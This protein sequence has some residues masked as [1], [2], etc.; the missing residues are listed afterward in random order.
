ML[1]PIPVTNEVELYL[2]QTYTDR[3]LRLNEFPELAQYLGQGYSLRKLVF[4][5][6]AERSRYVSLSVCQVSGRNRSTCEKQ[7]VF[8]SRTQNYSFEVAKD[9]DESL[10]RL[11]IEAEGPVYI[12][13]IKLVLGRE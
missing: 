1:D 7:R 5:A 6:Q 9:Y 4:T 12:H 11:R 3:E 8:M 10:R 2:E 13:K